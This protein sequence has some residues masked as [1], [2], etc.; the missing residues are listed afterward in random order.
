M[1]WGGEGGGLSYVACM[2]GAGEGLSGCH[3]ADVVEHAALVAAAVGAALQD[4]HQVGDEEVALQR[5]HALLRQ[6]G[7]LTAHR[8][9]QRQTVSRDVVLQTPEDRTYTQDELLENKE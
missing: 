3:G 2:V 7:R 8:A 9:R 5:R 4:V 6:D 1:G